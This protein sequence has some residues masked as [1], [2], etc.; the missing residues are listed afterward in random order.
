M[1][2]GAR[3]KPGTLPRRG[4]LR[5]LGLAGLTY[6]SASGGGRSIEGE[7]VA[8]TPG[9]DL[10]ILAPLREFDAPEKASLKNLAQLGALKGRLRN[11]EVV[12]VIP[13]GC[14]GGFRARFV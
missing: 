10:I 9:K 5:W 12:R 6:R 1:T 13:L 11:E 8:F 7:I 3:T 4:F 14:G 2:R